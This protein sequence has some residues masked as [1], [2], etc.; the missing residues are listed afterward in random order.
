MRFQLMLSN[1]FVF[2]F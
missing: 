2:V 1:C